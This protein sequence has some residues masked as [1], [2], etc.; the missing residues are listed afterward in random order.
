MA[1]RQG[2]TVLRHLIIV[3]R[4][5][6][7]GSRSPFSRSS[8]MSVLLMHY[9]SMLE[10]LEHSKSAMRQKDYEQVKRQQLEALKELIRS[11]PMNMPERNAALR[12]IRGPDSP[13]N[14]VLS[15]EE[16]GELVLALASGAGSSMPAVASACEREGP[17]GPKP[18]P[19][20]QPL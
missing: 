11:S 16:R 2:C 6:F 8:A 20:L 19:H 12:T 3:H 15:E 17:N 9:G 10:F 5:S 18:N 4:Y 1:L 13:N 14:A 7:V